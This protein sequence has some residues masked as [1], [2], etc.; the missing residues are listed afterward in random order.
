M[1]YTIETDKEW[2]KA[3]MKSLARNN[4]G[5]AEDGNYKKFLDKARKYMLESYLENIRYELKEIQKEVEEEWK[6]L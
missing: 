5:Y 2:I 4:Y 6:E 1:S 3:E